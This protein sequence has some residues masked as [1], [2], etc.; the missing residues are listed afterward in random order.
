MS[1]PV[2]VR[3]V[4]NKAD[5][6]AFMEFPW[7]LYKGD[8]N[9]VPNLLSMRRDLLDKKKNPSWEYME[10]DYFAAWRGDKIVGTISAHINHRH[11][12]FQKER[13]GWFGLFEVYDDQ[14]AA[15]ALLNT[16][17]EYVKGRGYD[18]IRGPQSF[19][20]HDEVGI[21]V[22]NFSAPRIMLPYNYPY[23][24]SLVEGAGFVKVMDAHSL[25]YDRDLL[26][27]TKGEER[28]GRLAERVKKRSN[29]TLRE[30]NKHKLHDEFVLFKEILNSAW[31]DNW[32]FVPMTDR[33]LDHLADSLGMFFDPRL[34]CFAEVN[35]DPAGFMITVPDLNQVL[36]R[37]YPRPGVPEIFTLMKAL[38]YW[39]I[40][41]V[42][43]WVRVPL[44]GVKK[45]YRDRGVELVM[46]QY[47]MQQILSGSQYNYL[48][49]SW[50]LESNK[51]MIGV[52]EGVGAK[53]YKTHRYYEKAL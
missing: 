4:E 10:G 15:T 44:M 18:R 28:M 50:I 3:K 37:A 27:E 24:S 41:P 5:L 34:A 46:F 48:D 47:I 49:S 43:D 31:T 6:K 8:P 53:I 14:E 40:R 38:W 1:N 2:I 29:I 13:I 35:G 33:E 19:T 17:G 11:N 7:A 21:L 20:F 16:A 32:G 9:W 42:I 51:D 39:K 52:L 26:R 22:N 36:H 45:E 30:I 12:E 23:Y 25:Y